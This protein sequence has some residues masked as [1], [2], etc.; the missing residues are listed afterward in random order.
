MTRLRRWPSFPAQLPDFDTSEVPSAPHELFLT[1]LAEAGEQVLAPHAVTLSTVDAEGA[2]DARVVI[3]RDVDE[4]G[5]YVSSSAESPKGQQLQAN[6]RAALTFFWPGVGRQVR[7][8]GPVSAETSAADY[9]DRSPASRAEVLVG[10][11]S[12]VLADPDELLRAADEADQL[13]Q[14]NQDQPPESWT[15]YRVEPTTVEFWQAAQDRRHVRL[16]YR[17]LG[18]GWV[19][20]RLWP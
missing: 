15:R 17:R 4:H 2:P 8:R 11:Q 18:A 10:R 13:V 5:F 6:P 3:L 9:R 14:R 7:A 19:T 1:W 20:E 12:E 16:R